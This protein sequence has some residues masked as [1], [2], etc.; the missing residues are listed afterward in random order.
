MSEM[1]WDGVYEQLLRSHLRFLKSA[2][3]LKGDADLRSLGLDSATTV[4]LLLALEEQ[5]GVDFPDEAMTASVW[6]T[7][8]TLWL[9]V[10][11]LA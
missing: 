8:A 9:A 10:S 7:P 11:A 4:E 3:P 6:S 1:S 2:E 5:Y